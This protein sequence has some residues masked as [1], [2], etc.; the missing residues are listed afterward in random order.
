MG[1]LEG[2][3]AGVNQLVV[4]PSGDLSSL[5]FALL[6]TSA[7]RNGGEHNYKDAAWLI[8]RMAI[9]Q[10]P[11]A[12]A[13]ALLHAEA[14][15]T[16]PRRAC[17]GVADPAF[18]QHRNGNAM[19]ALTQSC[20]AGAV[21]PALRA[22]AAARYPPRGEHGRRH[23]RRTTRGSTG[24][25][26]CDRKRCAAPLISS[27]SSI[28]R[29]MAAWRIAVSGD[30]ALRFRPRQAH[31]RQR[32]RYPLCERRIASLKLNAD[33]VVLARNTA[34]A[35]GTRFGGVAR[36][37]AWP[38][39]LRCRARAV[40]ASH[41]AVPSVATTK[42]MTDVF[43][44]RGGDSRNRLATARDIAQASTSHPFNWAVFTLIGDAGGTIAP[45]KTVERYAMNRLYLLLRA[46]QPW[47]ATLGSCRKSRGRGGGGIALE[48][49]RDG[50]SGQ[51]WC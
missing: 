42:L 17:F 35:G 49:G 13:F 36:W 1:P 8:R 15:I 12:R 39:F 16:P 2:D 34:A 7:P 37:K 32:R 46:W 29:P 26:R 30:P 22:A 10:V 51:A 44:R 3:L 38:T 48:A 40:L 9:S 25:C 23:A 21:D 41:W 50:G 11:S 43:A 33:L 19:A 47:L 28:S 5:P 18:R 20:E 14:A 27:A 6:V 45:M 4:A 24:R 31:R